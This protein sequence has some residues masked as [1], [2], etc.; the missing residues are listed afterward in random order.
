MEIANINTAES[1]P[2]RHAV[3]I[4]KHLL[5]SGD[6]VAC[7][8]YEFQPTP[9]RDIM[10][11]A[12]THPAES[13]WFVIDG[14]LE[15]NVNG[16]SVILKKG[17]VMLSPYESMKGSKAISTTPVKLLVVGSPNNIRDLPTSH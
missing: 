4:G 13:V 6:R 1:F 7:I 11:G 15:V 3:G 9:D 10:E 14:E 2:L 8:Y 5:K 12:H 16:E 17:D